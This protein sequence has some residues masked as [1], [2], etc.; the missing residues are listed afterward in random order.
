MEKQKMSIHRALA[1]LKLIDSRIS[2]GI[3]SIEPVGSM[4]L[5]KPVNNFIVKT[6]FDKNAISSLQS[7]KDLIERKTLIKSAIV[8]ANSKTMVNISG[9]IMSI[10]DAIIYRSV[11][12]M[13]K[14]LVNHLLDKLSQTKSQIK[15][16]NSLVNENALQLAKAA[17]QKDNVEINEGDAVAI[18]EP[19]IAK[20]EFHL[21][22]PINIY[23]VIS[24]LNEEIDSFESEVDAVLSEIN[25]ITL[26]EV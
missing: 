14:E 22:D 25:A 5:D 12:E 15:K 24:K 13:K 11:I 1:E 2:K 16:N 21:V 18:T 10:S 7:I 17:L 9:K 20:N 19:Y 26:I 23:D 3:L 4:Q 8:E 6:E